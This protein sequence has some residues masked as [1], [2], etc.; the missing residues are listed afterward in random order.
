[1]QEREVRKVAKGDKT[2]R[3]TNVEVA[4]F[5]QLFGEFFEQALVT[6]VLIRGRV[7]LN[8][9]QS[10]WSAR[11]THLDPQQLAKG[12]YSLASLLFLTLQP[13]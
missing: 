3:P 12:L 2:T 6:T 11:K 8:I 13:P 7:I 10:V 1:M 9:E 5:E 4:A